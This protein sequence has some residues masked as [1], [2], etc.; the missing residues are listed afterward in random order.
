MA[1]EERP[2][3]KRVIDGILDFFTAFF[4]IGYLIARFTGETTANGFSLNGMSAIVL[5]AAV[6]AYFVIGNRTGGTLWQRILRIPPPR[7]Q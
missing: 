6:I 4:G 5:F 7:G 3:W 2:F 1:G